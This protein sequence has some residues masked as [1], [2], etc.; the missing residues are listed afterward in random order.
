MR[1]GTW[2]IGWLAAAALL[3]AVVISPARSQ[4]AALEDF[5]GTWRL[6]GRRQVDRMDDA[7]DRVVDQM[8]LFIREIARGEIHGRLNPE[9]RVVI[10]V[11]D[12]RHV[13]LGYDA[14]G[15]QR[16]RLGAPA[17][18]LRGP[19]GNDIR[20]SLR[21]DRGRL[22]ARQDAGEGRRTNVFSVSAD[23]RRLTMAARIGAPQLP[24]DIRYR[25]TY[26]R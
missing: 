5:S 26:R 22:I 11:E 14:W 1:W 12:E 8:N 20:M 17:V 24:A 19:D 15:P 25:L 7:I 9:E 23:G 2:T 21:F 16:L 4:T 18:A 13:R 10:R 3:G 6:D